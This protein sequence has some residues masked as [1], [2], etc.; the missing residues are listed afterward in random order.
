MER[1]KLTFPIA[2]GLDVRAFAATTGAFF[3]DVRGYVHATGFILRPDG[4]V[5]EAVY[6]TGPTGRFTSAD[7]LFMIDYRTKKAS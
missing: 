5:D 7:A 3:D 6:S 1:E 2:Y 4:K